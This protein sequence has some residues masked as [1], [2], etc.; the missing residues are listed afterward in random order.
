MTGRGY[1]PIYGPPRPT[2]HR[3]PPLTDSCVRSSFWQKQY[4]DMRKRLG[5][6]RPN[7][8]MAI[9]RTTKGRPG[10]ED[11]R[12]LRDWIALGQD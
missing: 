5:P 6:A 1:D 11:I 4:R 9:S 12:I 2:Q 8:I 7:V 3:F 10:F